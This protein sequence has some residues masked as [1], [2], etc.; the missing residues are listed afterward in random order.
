MSFSL[1][2]YFVQGDPVPSIK[3]GGTIP[4]DVDLY[5]GGLGAN[6]GNPGTAALPLATVAGLLAKAPKAWTGH[7]RAYFRPGTY[8]FGGI[9]IPP[10]T[11]LGDGTPWEWIDET[12]NLITKGTVVAGGAPG[13]SVVVQCVT[14]PGFPDLW[15]GYTLVH[16]PTGNKCIITRHDAA[17]PTTFYASASGWAVGDAMDVML[18]GATLNCTAASSVGNGVVNDSIPPSSVLRW[19]GLIIT[20]LPGIN[21]VFYNTIFQAFCLNCQFPGVMFFVDSILDGINNNAASS[22]GIYF[23]GGFLASN[24]SELLLTGAV[25]FGTVVLQS[26]KLETQNFSALNF[27]LIRAEQSQIVLFGGLF[28]PGDNTLEARETNITAR[29]CSIENLSVNAT[30]WVLEWGSTAYLT[31]VGGVNA[32]L[33]TLPVKLSTGAK[34]IAAPGLLG[35]TV[36]GVAGDFLTGTIGPNSWAGL[37]A[38]GSYLDVAFG[39]SGAMSIQG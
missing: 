1:S 7:N 3:G 22:R 21:F 5:V 34:L 16:L 18:P 4:K 36:T 17:T 37:A 38:S 10:G 11:P 8:N 19:S 39:G 24:R 25:D 20:S 32:N 2:G 29:R 6:D 14:P 31:Q 23:K 13:D 12:P 33:G 9:N 30:G 28:S 26:G 15:A 35:N 27:S